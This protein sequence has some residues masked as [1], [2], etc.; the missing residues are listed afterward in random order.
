MSGEWLE[1][2]FSGK[3]SD[4]CSN[5]T[6]ED[7]LTL[8]CFECNIQGPVMLPYSST[9]TTTVRV[10]QSL[11]FFMIILAGVF[12]NSLVIGLVAKYKTLHTN[13][14]FIALQVVVLDL[15]LSFFILNALVNAIANQW[16][17]G[18][19]MCAI[20]ALIGSTTSL[21]RTLLMC[22]LVIDRYLSV[23]WPFKY[24]TYQAKITIGLSVA[25][26]LVSIL[27]SFP[28]L[29]GLLDCYTFSSNEWLCSIS[30]DCNNGC[31]V[32]TRGYFIVIVVPA[33][34]LPIFLYGRLFYKAKKINKV[35]PAANAEEGEARKR[36]WKTT[37]TF[38]LLFISV[39]VLILPTLTIN[40]ILEAVAPDS[41]ISYVII[42]ISN[43]MIFLLVVMDPI[44][45]MRNSDV[46]EIITKI[47]NSCKAKMQRVPPNEQQ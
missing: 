19:Y 38:S 9:L 22:V 21:E 39:L 13:S 32:Y 5:Y 37:I 25:S 15:I 7:N 23:F 43:S 8:M 10:L 2:M 31:S 11:F 33:T 40:L 27:A 30:S 34:V 1:D 16:L 45:I 20:S 47:K 29:P 14:F 18:E 17:F 35:T 12:L 41:P 42:A 4:S 36:E 6:E 44:V 24:P 28:M 26:W 3:E 46:R